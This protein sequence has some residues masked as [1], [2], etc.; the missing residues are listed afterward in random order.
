ME[1]LTL[2]E[3]GA[4]VFMNYSVQSDEKLVELYKSQKDQN[5]FTELYERYRVL[6]ETKSRKISSNSGLDYNT[7]HYKHLHLLWRAVATYDPNRGAAFRTYLYCNLRTG[8]LEVI[9]DQKYRQVFDKEGR[10]LPKEKPIGVLN[11][12]SSNK[13]KILVSGETADVA[14][15]LVVQEI[16]D[17]LKSKDERYPIIL[18]MLV[19]GY[20]YEEIGK[21][22]GKHKMWVCRI[23]A[24]I[25]KCVQEYYAEKNLPVK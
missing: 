5:A 19:E 20:T 8:A 16:Y 3:R 12:A 17:Y 7:I 25:A 11:K 18:R 1:N 22:F 2:I 23:K 9:R 10:R 6:L 21:A 24:K 15:S 4:S 14:D 13:F